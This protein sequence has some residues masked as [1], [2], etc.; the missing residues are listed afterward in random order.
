VSPAI[1]ILVLERTYLSCYCKHFGRKKP[2]KKSADLH[3]R[4]GNLLHWN[5]FTGLNKN[6]TLKIGWRPAKKNRPFFSTC[7][8]GPSVLC[9]SRLLFFNQHFKCRQNFD[10]T[11]DLLLQMAEKLERG[12]RVT[13][14]LTCFARF[15]RINLLVGHFPSVSC[16]K[17][18]S[19]LFVELRVADRKDV[20]LQIADI[21]ITKPNQ[22]TL[23]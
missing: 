22:Y 9:Q 4:Q 2:C 18:G 14:R 6:F 19:T 23:T 13:T 5:I 1:E 16:I 12:Q 15:N 10:R 21:Y 3:P 17:V 8:Y 20:D 7:V 11:T